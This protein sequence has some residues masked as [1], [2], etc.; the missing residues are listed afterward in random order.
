[1]QNLSGWLIFRLKFEPLELS[2]MKQKCCPLNCVVAVMQLTKY[3]AVSKETV[4]ER[5]K[6]QLS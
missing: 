6:S 2:D 3:H 4:S 1:M 5:W